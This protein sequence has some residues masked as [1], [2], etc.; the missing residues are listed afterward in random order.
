MMRGL[1]VVHSLLSFVGA[2]PCCRIGWKLEA[3]QWRACWHASL[4][5]V[6][7]TWYCGKLCCP[8]KCDSMCMKQTVR[9]VL[10]RGRC[11]HLLRKE[12]IGSHLRCCCLRHRRLLDVGL[13]GLHDRHLPCPRIVVAQA[14]RCLQSARM[15]PSG[16][17]LLC[18]AHCHSREHACAEPLPLPEPPVQ[19]AAGHRTALAASAPM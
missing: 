14:D 15:D 4:L 1:L 6:V 19:T 17:H 18:R 3:S 7:S 9:S 16:R 2:Q 12:R 11:A 5:C 10:P 8:G 13:Q